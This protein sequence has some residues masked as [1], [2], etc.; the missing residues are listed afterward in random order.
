MSTYVIF[1]VNSIADSEEMARYSREGAA[2]TAKHKFKFLAGP[3]PFVQLEGV[4]PLE[5]VVLLEFEDR[6]A[7]EAWYYSEDYQAARRIREAAA[8]TS[9]LMIDSAPPRR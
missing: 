4:V 8:D 5:R 1:R 2:A 3:G 9:V 6:A 7:A